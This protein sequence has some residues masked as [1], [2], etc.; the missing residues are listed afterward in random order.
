LFIVRV[1]FVD[2]LDFFLEQS[3]LP[4][5]RVID[6]DIFFSLTLRVAAYLL[7]FH[8][9]EIEQAVS[10]ADEVWVIRV[11]VRIFDLD[12]VLDHIGRRRQTLVKNALHYVTD[13]AL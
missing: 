8:L 9:E 11:Y 5:S 12:E 6:S 2:I 3:V 7:L 10:A 13:L 4:T 1:L